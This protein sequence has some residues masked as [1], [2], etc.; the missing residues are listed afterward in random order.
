MTLE[1]RREAFIEHKKAKMKQA[2]SLV[3]VKNEQ[4]RKI[5]DFLTIQNSDCEI[6]YT[7]LLQNECIMEK[8]GNEENINGILQSEEIYIEILLDTVANMAPTLLGS[9]GVRKLKSGR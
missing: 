9:N 3:D 4:N 2:Q 5:T 7:S 1:K 8:Y 6:P